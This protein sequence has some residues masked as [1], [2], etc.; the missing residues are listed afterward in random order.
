MNIVQSDT[1]NKDAEICK[2]SIYI[3]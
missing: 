2:T 1:F 3:S